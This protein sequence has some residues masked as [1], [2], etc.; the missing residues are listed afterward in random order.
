[1]LIPWTC[2]IQKFGLYFLCYWK[3]LH[4]FDQ[5]Y[6]KNNNIM[7]YYYNLKYLISDL[8]F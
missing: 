7:K 5:K 1:M 8:M 2:I 6:S 4:L 3:N